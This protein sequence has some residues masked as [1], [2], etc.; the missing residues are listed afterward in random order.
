MTNRTY[1]PDLHE[2]LESADDVTFTEH[3]PQALDVEAFATYLAFQEIVD[4]YHDVARPGEH[5]YVC[6]DTATGALAVIDWALDVGVG[7]RQGLGDAA[8][9]RL[10]AERFLTQPGFAALVDAE[11]ER[12]SDVLLASDAADSTAGAAAEVLRRHTARLH[13]AELPAPMREPRS[14]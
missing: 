7:T 5:A 9:A 10:L 2:L 6:F 3:L 13:A 8:A 1:T 14:A 12:L 4:S 11:L